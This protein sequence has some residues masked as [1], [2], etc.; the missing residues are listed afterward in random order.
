VEV[1]LHVF[2][3]S[4]LGDE[5]STSRSRRLILEERTVITHRIGNRVNPRASLDME[6]ENIKRNLAPY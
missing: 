5:W 4:A 3:T 1:N 2:L 6:V